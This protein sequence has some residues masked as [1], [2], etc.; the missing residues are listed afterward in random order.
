MTAASVF[1][2]IVIWLGILHNCR[3]LSLFGDRC[4]L[5]IFRGSYSNPKTVTYRKRYDVVDSLPESFVIPASGLADLKSTEPTVVFCRQ[6]HQG[7]AVDVIS[8]GSKTRPEY[9]SMMNYSPNIFFIT[10]I[11]VHPQLVHSH[12][13]AM[14]QLTAQINTWASHVNVRNFWGFTEQDDYNPNC[15]DMSD[16]SFESF[17]ESCRSPTLWHQ[18][19][20]G[21]QGF[22]EFQK[23]SQ[24]NF[25]VAT[26]K[27]KIGRHPGWVCAQRRPGRALGWLQ[28][29][30]QNPNVIP[31]ILLIV[32]DDT[33]LVRNSS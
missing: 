27:R 14:I 9:V 13:C 7:V 4:S 33:S 22:Q 19:R 21:Q 5:S 11:M 17:V 20:G 26:K 6:D 12:H 25:G 10:T 30:Y 1:I 8:I 23:M 3:T 15:A 31:E 24:T 29:M 18:D 32:D 2:A 28:V 16:A